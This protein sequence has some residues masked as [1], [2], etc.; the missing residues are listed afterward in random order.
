MGYF[1]YSSSLESYKLGTWNQCAN[2]RDI[3]SRLNYK[4]GPIVEAPNVW[5]F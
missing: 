5:V 2:L 4:T 3:D 1:Y